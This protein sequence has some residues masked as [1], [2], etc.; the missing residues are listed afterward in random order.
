MLDLNCKKVYKIISIIFFVLINLNLNS[1]SILS[2]KLLFEKKYNLDFCENYN[3]TLK[4]SLKKAKTYKDINYGIIQ[5]SDS[6]YSLGRYIIPT[7]YN[8][9]EIDIVKIFSIGK[10]WI[11][12]SS[13]FNVKHQKQYVFARIIDSKGHRLTKWK[14]ILDI[15]TDKEFLTNGR[16]YFDFAISP[17]NNKFMVLIKAKRSRMIDSLR[18]SFV[19]FDRELNVINTKKAKYGANSYHTDFDKVILTNTNDVFLLGVEFYDMKPFHIAIVYKK[20]YTLFHFLKDT[21]ISKKVKLDNK[22]I[23]S[24]TMKYYKDTLYLGGYYSNQ[25]CYSMAGAFSMKYKNE[26]LKLWSLQ[27]FPPYLVKK[28]PLKGYIEKEVYNE[29]FRFTAQS[30]EVD[31]LDNVYIIGQK[32]FGAL[33]IGGS[34]KNP[35]YEYMSGY[36]YKYDDVLLFKIS[37]NDR[38]SKVFKTKFE[39]NKYVMHVR[40]NVYAYSFVGNSFCFVLND[41][42]VEEKSFSGKIEYS[43]NVY[44]IYLDGRLELQKSI[45]G[46]YSRTHYN[47]IPEV[48]YGPMYILVREAYKK[49]MGRI[50]K[51]SK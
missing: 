51:I 17:D 10:N 41:K 23:N 49:Q 29:M 44:S 6:L 22:F 14:K 18:Y 47:G 13:F 8:Q 36:Y 32:V 4:F 16:E 21:I 40:P 38:W 28:Y 19:V 5:F 9:K 45:K 26:D 35:L 15:D 43:A 48:F 42:V 2:S 46:L 25:E 30:I 20:K 7:E 31:S 39:T 50:V 34:K 12:L 11:V 3:G 33:L 37:E 24:L 27:R 1:Q